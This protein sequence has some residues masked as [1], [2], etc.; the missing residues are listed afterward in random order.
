MDLRRSLH[1]LNIA[2]VLTLLLAAL[3]LS[4][5]PVASFAART[6]PDWPNLHLVSVASVLASIAVG[7][8]AWTIRSFEVTSFLALLNYL[9]ATVL[10][11]HVCFVG[12]LIGTYLGGGIVDTWTAQLIYLSATLTDSLTEL[13]HIGNLKNPPIFTPV[14]GP[15]YYALL[16]LMFAPF[17]EAQY[18]PRLLSSASIL[19]TA[20]ALG[21][22]FHTNRKSRWALLAPAL[23]LASF[24]WMTW[25]GA[26]TKPEFTACAF[27]MWGFAIYLKRGKGTNKSWVFPSATLFGIALLIK[28][29]IIGALGATILHLLFRR[30]FAEFIYFFGIILLILFG[31]YGFLILST[32]GGIVFFTIIAN[33]AKPL[34]FTILN[35]GILGILKSAFIVIV[36]SAA[37]ILVFVHWRKDDPW[38]AIPFA[39]FLALGLSLIAI[40]R[41]G[42]S[43]NYFLEPVIL[44]SLTLAALRHHYAQT[45]ETGGHTLFVTFL[46]VL[47]VVNLPS[48]AALL[49]RSHTRPEEARATREALLDLKTDHDEYVM[50]DSDYV[51][52]VTQAGHKPVLQNNLHYTLMYDNGLVDTGPVMRILR[53]GKVPYLVLKN[54]LEW[55]ASVGY[56]V[57]HY[58]ADV[59][60]FMRANYH[61]QE[62]LRKQ[63]YLRL[64]ICRLVSG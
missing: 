26:P 35:V 58:P 45:N 42:S 61:C 37:I 49:A 17:G 31:V 5:G 9:L 64:I 62:V 15:G 57:R 41:P 33:A 39:L 43:A 55:H 60:E 30:R 4:A 59:I 29:T 2:V 46:L 48:Q 12:M 10:I 16:K 1:L 21:W 56:G 22:V 52:E 50:V 6:L 11:I 18:V 20:A 34:F 44:G 25:S 51:F 24:P 54:T 53:A 47:M 38:N 63:N 3:T 36:L 40:G 23:F 32:G 27:S 13:Y 28:F 14:Y 19:L 7:G 8:Y